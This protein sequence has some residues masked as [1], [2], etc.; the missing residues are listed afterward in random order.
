MQ[1]A[2]RLADKA[3]SLMACLR[4]LHAQCDRFEALAGCAY[5]PKDS[6]AIGAFRR[7]NEPPRSTAV[8]ARPLARRP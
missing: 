7:P 5:S 1:L 2:T 6:S 4:L 3:E 8:A